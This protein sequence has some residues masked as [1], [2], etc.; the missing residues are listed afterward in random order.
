MNELDVKAGDY[1]CV[2]G[3]Y[4]SSRVILY[5]VE[6][7]TKTQAVCGKGNK[8]RLSDGLKIGTS[9]WYVVHGSKATEEDLYQYKFQKAKEKVEQ[10]LKGKDLDKDLVIEM[11]K[12]ID[13]GEI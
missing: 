2:F 6:R 11:A 10:F 9:G 1:I 12:L 4:N 3:R 13:G 5:K 8:F 7:L